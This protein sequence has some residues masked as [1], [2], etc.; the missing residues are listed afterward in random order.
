VSD[1]AGKAVV[2]HW[3]ALDETAT[4]PQPLMV[5]PLTLK[6][7]VPVAPVVSAALIVTL[8]P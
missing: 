6:A 8:A 1:P 4:A 7:T 3:A 5:E 2:T